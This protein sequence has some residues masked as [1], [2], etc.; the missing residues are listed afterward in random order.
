MFHRE[1]K[2]HGV[3]DQNEFIIMQEMGEK[4]REGIGGQ[5]VCPGRGGGQCL[6]RLATYRVPLPS[7]ASPAHI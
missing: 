2:Q 3:S 4:D 5:S 6:E 7:R 1:Y